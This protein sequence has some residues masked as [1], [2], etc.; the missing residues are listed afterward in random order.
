MLPTLNTLQRTRSITTAFK[1]LNLSEGITEGEWAYM[2]NMDTRE[3]P[4]LTRRRARVHVA[5]LQK[6]NGMC[7]TDK[8]CFVDGKK[9]YYN[10]YYYGDVEDS[11]KTLVPMGA[12]IAIFPDKVLFSTQ[13]CQFTPM[14]QQN[15]TTGTVTVTLAQGDG[16]PYG[17][18]TTGATAPETP[19][20]GALWLDTGETPPAMKRY[21]TAQSMWVEEAT[22]YVQ[23]K[24]AGIGKGLKADDGV[25]VTG[26]AQEDLNGD[27][28]LK[29]AGDD[30]ILF[31]GMLVEEATQTAAVTVA[32]RCPDMEFVVEK[33]NRLW[34]CSSA[35]HEIYCC[36]L[37][38]ATNWRAYEGISTDAYAVTVGT[39]GTFTGA[40]VIGSAVVFFKEHCIHKIYGTAPS[41]FQMYVDNLRGVQAGCGRSV[42]RVQEYLYYK[43]PFD[44]CVYADSEVAGISAAL[45]QQAYTEAVAGSCGSRLY[46]SMKDSTGA[47]HLLCYDVE[48]GLWCREDDTQALAFASCQTETFMLRAD[49]KI[50]ALLPGSYNREFFMVGQDYVVQAAEETDA[51]IPWE[52]RTGQLARELPDNKFISRIQLL[53]DAAE[54]AQAVI[55]L[56]LNG[57]A[58]REVQTV[59][60]A[61][62]QRVTLPLFPK[63]CDHFELRLA[64]T[65]VVKL[66]NWNRYVAVGSEL[67]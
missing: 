8:L 67:R 64:G 52:A 24:G 37:G 33:D 57:G 28:V 58:W 62:V 56:R 12:Y 55:S 10:G 4:A 13:T 44:V 66:L 11:A 50:F 65:G 30:F 27:W 3:A 9:F 21:S 36:R 39:P 29:A 46:L 17:A 34:G 59:E 35:E 63:R 54:G 41:N 40:A 53:L 19:E 1:G 2:Q 14:E 16:T 15:V 26:L 23:V 22:T 25:S 42:A 20:N 47:W 49:G 6:P 18:H 48:T 43:S 45:G 32:R 51:D 61:G 31:V 38:D 7:A 60:T 5:T